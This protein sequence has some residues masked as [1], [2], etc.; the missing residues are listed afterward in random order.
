MMSRPSGGVHVPTDGLTGWGEAA[1][2]VGEGLSAALMGGARVMEERAR[3]TTAG[4]LAD[5]SERLQSIDRETR[6]EL[7]GREVQDWNYTWR[8]LTGP[9]LAEA[10]DELSPDSR[11]AARQ[12]AEAYS[13]RASVEAQ[14]DYELSR[15][16]KARAQWRTQV[17]SAVESGDSARAS[18]WLD[19]GQGI[20]LPEQQ[21]EAAKKNAASRAALSLWQRDLQQDPLGALNRLAAAP[22]EQMPQQEA[23]TRSLAHSRTSALRSARRE[24][25][26]RLVS[27]VESGETPEP[28]YVKLA[29]DAGVL[30]PEQSGSALQEPGR[31]SHEDGRNWLQRIDECAYE[32][33]DETDALKL[34]IATAALPAREKRRLLQRVELSRGLPVRERRRLSMGLLSL[35]RS[36][37][38]GCP[39]DA[40]V[41]Q[42]FADLQQQSL[43]RLAQEGS[44]STTKW[45]NRMR[46][47]ADRWVCF[48]PSLH[49]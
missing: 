46:D 44:E 26:A 43:A 21:V 11:S 28:A 18:E 49:A 13:A 22:A 1:R 25:L 6:E 39:A 30:N 12:L 5:F 31:L 24:V 16:D 45:V 27:C 36:G 33:D 41:Q 42:H 2:R 9:K 19:A 29:G 47:L 35:Y 8:E 38:L 7:V 10:I 4:E 23:D 15:I 32:D 14:R 20:F 37:A 17:D 48:T 40:E 3:V 34:D